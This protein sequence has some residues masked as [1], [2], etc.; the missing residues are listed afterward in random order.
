MP[1]MNDITFRDLQKGF[2]ELGL[3]PESRVL[4]HTALSAFGHV[5]GGAEALV[6]ALTSTCRLVVVPTFTEQCQILPLVG[7]AENGMTYGD[8]YADNAEAE[9]FLPEVPAHADMGV[10]AET[11]RHH[12]DARRSSHPLL[13]FAAVGPGAA[14]L[15]AAQTLAE[16]FAPLERLA[17]LG[18]DVLLLGVDHTRNAAVHLAERRAGRKQF[19]RW[20]FTPAGV[21]QC[22]AWPGCSEG[23]AALDP[24]VRALTRTARVGG[25]LLQRLPLADLLSAA[26][27]LILSDPTALL[28]AREDCERCAAVRRAVSQPAG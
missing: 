13:S 23:F 9:M 7:P 24:H 15:L 5:R 26:E 12:P 14:E 1:P 19:V 25:A 3:T 28:C 11:L 16:P 10:T 4:A 27:A 21:V 6:A 18:G 22:P 2:R 20:A 17:E 8:R